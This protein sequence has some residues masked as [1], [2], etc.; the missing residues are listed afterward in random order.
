MRIRD[1]QEQARKIL[2]HS[3]VRGPKASSINL[4]PHAL[5]YIIKMWDH[6]PSDIS[7]ILPL[8]NSQLR[9]YNQD[10]KR[11]ITLGTLIIR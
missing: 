7:G 4:W 10:S 5:Q 8:E 3:V 6:L 2:L 1:L 11:F 9:R